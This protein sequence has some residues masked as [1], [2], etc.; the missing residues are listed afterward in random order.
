MDFETCIQTIKDETD[1]FLADGD[2]KH[3]RGVEAAWVRL[4]ELGKAEEA[5]VIFA[6]EAAAERNSARS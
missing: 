3:L 6:Q 2:S 1:A 4:R 5:D